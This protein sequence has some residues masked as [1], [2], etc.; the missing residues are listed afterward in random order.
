MA[1][2]THSRA[3]SVWANG[4]RIG[5]WRLPARGPTEFAYDAAWIGS[6]AGWPLSLSLHFAPGNMAHKGPRVAL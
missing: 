4:E 5:V 2:P 3:L 6:P 1:R